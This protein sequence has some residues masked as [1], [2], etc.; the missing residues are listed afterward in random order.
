MEASSTPQI[1]WNLRFDNETESAEYS[2]SRPVKATAGDSLSGKL[3]LRVDNEIPPMKL[4]INFRGK[5]QAVVSGKDPN[6]KTYGHRNLC[7]AS[8]PIE[9]SVN[10]FTRG[11]T[12][13]YPFS[14]VLPSSL[15]SSTRGSDGKSR[16]RIIYKVE[17]DAIYKVHGKQV[18]NSGVIGRTLYVTS[19]PLRDERV[20]ACIEPQ[21]FSIESGLGL[22]PRGHLSLAARV[23]DVHIGRG[24]LL[25]IFLSCRNAATASI[26]NVK[27]ELIEK[28]QCSTN[29]SADVWC[30]KILACIEDVHLPSLQKDKESNKVFKPFGK[31]GSRVVLENMYEELRSDRNNVQLLIPDTAVDSYEAG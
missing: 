9:D 7:G 21:S 20:P 17:V 26:Q 11:R 4:S 19:A 24:Q 22:V 31:K 27:L 30:R 15:P 28:V 29:K 12:H 14:F 18:V 25:K 8:I 2:S 16:W 5:E 1:Q 10:I 13:S 23:A 3:V 6:K